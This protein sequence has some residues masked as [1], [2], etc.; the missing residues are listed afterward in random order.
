[1]RQISIDVINEVAV[2]DTRGLRVKRIRTGIMEAVGAAGAVRAVGVA[3]GA[4][5]PPG[6]RSTK[7]SRVSMVAVGGCI[8]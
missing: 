5:Q 2:R 6:V 3:A 1:L 4:D 7:N 8:T